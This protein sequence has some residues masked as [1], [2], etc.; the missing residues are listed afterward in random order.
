MPKLKTNKT[1]MARVKRT[2]NGKLVRKRAFSAHLRS[3]KSS[4]ARARTGAKKV[5]SVRKYP[6]N[7]LLQG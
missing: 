7:K 6:W 5:D 3:K 2:P 4:S 1:L